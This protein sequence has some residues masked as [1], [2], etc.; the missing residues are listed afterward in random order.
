MLFLRYL[1]KVEELIDFEDPYDGNQQSE[2]HLLE[3]TMDIL[4]EILSWK[5]IVRMITAQGVG[6]IYGAVGFVS[7]FQ[8]PFLF[9][10]HRRILVTA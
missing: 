9:A 7:C 2:E 5:K 3:G 1:W 4:T 8:N 6:C 10:F